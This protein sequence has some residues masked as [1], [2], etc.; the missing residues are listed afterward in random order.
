VRSLLERSFIRACVTLAV[1]AAWAA[2]APRFVA[3]RDAGA[4]FVG[5]AGAEEGLAREVAAYVRSGVSTSAF[6]TGSARFDGEW[7]VVTHQMAALGLGQIALRRPELRAAYLPV[8]ELCLER[9]L[10][11]DTTAFGT[12][13]WGER[14]LDRADSEGGHAYLGYLNLAFGMLRLLDRETR[15]A[16][17]HDRVTEALARRL[18][19]APH[20]L[21]E[22][23]PGEAYP[24][25]VAAVIGSIGLYDRAT[26]ADHRALLDRAAG[27]YRDRFVDRGSGL[28]HQMADAKTGRPLGPPRASGTSI[29]VYFLSFASP[30]SPAFAALSRDLFAALSDRQRAAFLGFGGVREHAPGHEGGG[31]IDSGPVVFGVSVSASGFAL[32]GAKIYG[33][34]ALFT[35]LYRTAHLFGV[36]VR[37]GSGGSRFMSGGPIGN[38]IL[39]AMMTAAPA[40]AP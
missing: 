12:E 37:R 24:A 27:T 10:A 25:D 2:S 3:G 11:P 32:A 1:I 18:A 28:L 39:L 34:R 15:F 36:P 40:E 23:Y 17:V 7:T 4:Y 21:I 20:A 14:G 33:D 38:A 5:E 35:E 9:L 19:A 31:D 13:A 6:H 22:T 8:I 26:G 16:A 29:A 30:A